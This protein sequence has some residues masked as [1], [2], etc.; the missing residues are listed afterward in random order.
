M[1]LALTIKKVCTHVALVSGV[2]GQRHLNFLSRFLKDFA[3]QSGGTVVKSQNLEYDG[4][5][6]LVLQCVLKLSPSFVGGGGCQWIY[7]LFNVC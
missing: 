4:N 1:F 7:E 6:C 3:S 2:G 5:S